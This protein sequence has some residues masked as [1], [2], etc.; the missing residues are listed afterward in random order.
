MGEPPTPGT[1]LHADRNRIEHLKVPGAEADGSQ[2]AQAQ[3]EK[4]QQAGF[5]G[6]WQRRFCAGFYGPDLQQPRSRPSE[7]GSVA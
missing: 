1:A 3:R 5:R 4:A 2:G 6:A 7:V